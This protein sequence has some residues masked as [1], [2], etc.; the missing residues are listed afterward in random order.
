MLNPRRVYYRSESS[1]DFIQLLAHLFIRD[2]LALKSDEF[3]LVFI[4]DP[5]TFPILF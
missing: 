3:H 5:N 1:L 2:V 4:R